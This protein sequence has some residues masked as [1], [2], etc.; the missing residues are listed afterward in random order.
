VF[1]SVAEV[2]LQVTLLPV[3]FRSARGYY[4]VC[5]MMLSLQPTQSTMV[6]ACLRGY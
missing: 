1:G 2:R 3:A 6:Y 4:V 5:S